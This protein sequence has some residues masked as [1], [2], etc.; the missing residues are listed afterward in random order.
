MLNRLRAN[1][2]RIEQDLSHSHERRYLSPA[3]YTQY[4]IALPL[5][6]RYVH[7]EMID[8]G[9]GRMPF[10]ELLAGQVS[11]YHSLDFQ[12]QS[13]EVTFI[14]DIQEMTMI[15]TARYDSAICL[16]VLEHVPHPFQAALEIHRILKPGG[17]LVISVPHLSRLHDE[18]HDYFRF[19]LYGL[20]RLLEDSGFEIIEIK[21]NGG[22]LSFWGHQVSSLL[23]TMCWPVPGLRQAAWLVNKWLITLP[24]YI[25]D[26]W[27]DQDGVFALGY[28]GVARKPHAATF[29][30][31]T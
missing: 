1:R 28:A 16:E 8:L 18:P 21:K 20:R 25:M 13:G 23:L 26:N 17:L 12:S 11:T 15:S 10:R 9:C 7:G 19:T 27:F 29:E 4:Q 30:Q 2:K 31:S 6:K 5:A 24:C 22:L 14:G 3:L